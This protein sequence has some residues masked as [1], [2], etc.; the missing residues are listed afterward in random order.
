[1][2]LYQHTGGKTKVD[3]VNSR[4]CRRARLNQ[5]GF[6]PLPAFRKLS[7]RCFATAPW[8][9]VVAAFV[10][11]IT[12]PVRAAVP[13]CL[14]DTY[15]DGLQT[16][17]PQGRIFI[18]YNTQL[19]GNPDNTL[20]TATY[21][22]NGGSSLPSCGN[23]DCIASGSPVTP[24]ELP[25][26]VTS[27][28]NTNITVP[29]RSSATLGENGVRQY[30]KVTLNSGTTLNFDAASHSPN[31][32]YVI[33]RLT[34]GYKGVVNLR[35]GTYWV[36]KLSINS[37]AKIHVVGSGTVRLMVKQTVNIGYQSELNPMVGGTVDASRLVLV[38]YGN[39]SLHSKAVVNAIVYSDGN[40]RIGNRSRITGAVAADKITAYR[41]GVVIYQE[42]KSSACF[43]DSSDNDSDGDGVPDADDAFPDDPTE[44][45]DLDGDGIGDNAD[46][47]RDGD[48]IGNDYEIQLGTDPDDSS[49]TPPDLDG[50]GVP[51]SLDDDRDGD[52][53]SNDYE[54]Q[55]GADPDDGNDTP[56]DLDGDGMP[57]S[58]DDDRDG[59]SVANDADSFPDDATRS[60]LEAI[61]G[62]QVVQQAQQVVLSW[63][64]HPETI[65]VGYHVERS[66]HGADSWQRLT[67]T[68]QLDSNFTD[69]AVQN[70]GSYDY[71]VFAIDGRDLESIASALAS[72]FFAFNDRSVTQANIDWINYRA[73]LGWTLALEA[74]E[75]VRIYRGDIGAGDIAY[76]DTGSGFVDSNSHWA[77]N[78]RYQVVSVLSFDNLITGLAEQREGPAV[79]LLLS[80]LPPITVELADVD[81][82]GAY[83]WQVESTTGVPLT[84]VGTVANAIAPVDVNLV[85]GAESLATSVSNQ[86]F[87]FLL[88]DAQHETI[89]IS[90]VESGAPADRNVSLT[91][92]VIVDNTPLKLQ[93]DNPAT[94]TTEAG[95]I[96]VNGRV[97]NVDGGVSQLSASSD[98]IPGLNF[99]LTLVENNEFFGELPL[100][101]GD[102][103]MQV[104]VVAANG[105]S[106]SA[107]FDVERSA[108]AVPAIQF[109]T[110][111][112]NQ[113]VGESEITIGGRLYS[114][115]AADEIQLSL[116]GEAV[117]I[118]PVQSGV[119]AFTQ[120]G[121]VLNFGFNQ[122]VAQAQ[123][124]LGSNQA[125]IV[126]YFQDSQSDL[127]Q[128]LALELT[129]PNDQQIVND[130]TLLVRGQL[131]NAGSDPEVLVNG[132]PMALFGSA[133]SGWL[134]NT[135]IDI[136]A[137]TEGDV[138]VTVDA[139]STGKSPLQVTRSVTVDRVEPALAIDNALLDLPAVNEIT[140]SPLRI[141]GSVSDANL[142]A[143]TINGLPVSLTPGSG[144]NS[145]LFSSD[146]LLP[147]G[148][149]TSLDLV[150]VDRAGNEASLGYEV[151]SNP[152]P[153]IEVIQ[154]LADSEYLVFNDS[155]LIETIARVNNAPVDSTLTVQAGTVS[156]QQTVSQEIISTGLTVTADESI[157][158]LRF[159]L[160]DV[161]GDTLASQSLPITIVDAANIPLELL[162]T[163]PQQSDQFREP[164]FPVQFYFNRPVAL[165]DISVSV[166]QTVHGQSY[167]AERKSGAGL[168]ETYQGDTVEV[169]KDQA[170]VAGALSLLPGERIVEFY[171]DT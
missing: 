155:Q 76:E 24:Q 47:D 87:Q 21:S 44:W 67:A 16:H 140:E 80:A 82:L 23:V 147:R 6:N 18:G 20:G 85:R 25:E 161:N 163:V 145:Y 114:S 52:G 119:Y 50:D 26:F 149:Q 136:S 135:G 159:I 10:L 165:A 109:T 104:R 68:S 138:S 170:P 77:V 88:R 164:H 127:D 112:P 39:F 93:L 7:R 105:E 40:V 106:A 128:P 150:A 129:T 64:A 162:Q 28:V 89:T 19:L 30:R 141:S 111:S 156:S 38:T 122:I 91:L 43:F 97:L 62:L 94:I 79:E 130:D 54:T 1:M 41:S 78:Q 108:S 86:Q 31:D 57:D 137:Q 101:F 55:V 134:F 171:P 33:D 58:L 14:A 48:G 60:I 123:T 117:A 151:L 83:S 143:V 102:N 131:L 4:I 110:H 3:S 153:A 73:S 61:T 53:I 32:E 103:Q 160:R 113:V 100:E 75:S 27:P 22:Q 70:G 56:P 166:R 146:L 168:G 9:A 90:L 71:R 84:I 115:L 157:D 17:S 98:R 144:P 92:A 11:L 95:S 133:Q 2:K 121:V 46:P 13:T 66:S 148:Q 167:S 34:I 107:S 118:S 37:Q 96:E 152:G 69:S 125:A 59:D 12:Q 29:W 36:R 120:P 124:P 72:Q 99:G 74:N 51:D 158:E 45:A 142:A 126:I 42:P 81:A 169:H 132:V 15:F 65:V 35:A 139:S 5:D 49:S 63:D 154:P 8:F 116:N